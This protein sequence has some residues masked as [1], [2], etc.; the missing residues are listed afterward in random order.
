V[1]T[2]AVDVALSRAADAA[3]RALDRI[4]GPGGSELE[5]DPRGDRRAARELDLALDDLARAIA[6][7][8]HE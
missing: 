1:L 4:D 5:A 3:H 7:A 8:P 6:E 2:P